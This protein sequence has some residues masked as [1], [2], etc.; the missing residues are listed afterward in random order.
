MPTIRLPIVPTIGCFPKGKVGFHPSWKLAVCPIAGLPGANYVT[1]MDRNTTWRKPGLRSGEVDV[2]TARVSNDRTRLI[3]V[4][5]VTSPQRD[6]P[7]VRDEGRALVFNSDIL[8]GRNRR[9]ASLFHPDPEGKLI[10]A[11]N[12]NNAISRDDQC[13]NSDIGSLQ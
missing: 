7:V 3:P 13:V 10:S 6:I 4:H 11:E 12:T 8:R 2:Q 9:P 1:D 5:W